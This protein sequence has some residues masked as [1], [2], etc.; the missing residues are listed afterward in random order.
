LGESYL[1]PPSFAAKLA[2]NATY[3]PSLL[4]VSII[5][6]AVLELAAVMWLVD[7]VVGRKVRDDIG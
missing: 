7:T 4:F 5:A 3:A 2:A 1:L 6:A